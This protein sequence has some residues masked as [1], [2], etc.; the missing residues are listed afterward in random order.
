MA[1]PQ[2]VREQIL[3]A[4]NDL[5]P[6]QRQLAR[7]FLD[8]EEVVAFASANEIGEQA[9]AS[10]ATVV[11]F[12]RAL[13]YQ[14]YTDLQ[15]AIRAQFPQY[16]TFVQKLAEHMSN[17]EAA[18]NRNLPAQIAQTNTENIQN[19]LSRVS[20][21]ELVSAVNSIVAAKRI[22]IFGSG[23]SA[24]AAVFAEHSLTT[25]GFSARAYPNGGLA[26]VMEISHL[27]RQDVVIAISVWRYLRSTVDAV[28][29]AQAAGSTCIVFTDSPV[30]PIAAMADHVFVANIE[31]AMHSRSI[32]GI[33]SLI[34]LI[35]AAIVARRPQK[36]MEALQ[37]IDSL[38][39]Q[40]GMLWS[41]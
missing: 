2:N 9:G 33:L 30:A 28:K 38:Y 11:R 34:D 19:S 16:R 17:G 3:A 1:S 14:G 24:A 37:R 36:S 4:F 20:D 15:A 40:G 32:T 6:K 21:A 25:L 31:G 41:D 23:V 13:G 39:R 29:A 27:G 7:F 18:F 26:Q 8:N 5:S 22:R 10:A 12:C 35:S